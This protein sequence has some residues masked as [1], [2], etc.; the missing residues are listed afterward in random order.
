[1]NK[2]NRRIT[3]RSMC[4]SNTNFS[5]SSRNHFPL[6]LASN[7]PAPGISSSRHLSPNPSFPRQLRRALSLQN[8][9]AAQQTP[10]TKPTRNRQI[11]APLTAWL[12]GP[13][14][15]E[16]NRSITRRDHKTA[17]FL[18]LAPSIRL[19]SSDLLLL[20]RRS[21][22]STAS[23]GGGSSSTMYRSRA[24]TTHRTARITHSPKCP[25]LA[26]PRYAD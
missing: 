3:R 4:Q 21:S 17:L 5:L 19:R 8:L 11:S 10:N 1:M 14:L 26:P 6:H 15:V 16:F 9:T 25:L 20:L 23:S 22:T 13:N 24:S 12:R 7:D 2:N 18:P